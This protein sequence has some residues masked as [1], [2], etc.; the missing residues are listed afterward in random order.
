MALY[1][2]DGI[3]IYNS[4]NLKD[5][6]YES[7]V[8]GFYECP[9]LFELPVDGDSQQKKW[10]MLGAS[11]TYMIGSF[12]GKTFTPENG[13]YAYTYWEMYAAQTFG[14]MNG[15][16][17]QIGWGRPA[18]PGMPFKSM[19][20]IPTELSLVTTKDGV[21]LKSYPIKE[22]DQLKTSVGHWKNLEVA[23]A[24]EKI[25]TF[26]GEEA[27]CIKATIT[28]AV[29]GRRFTL[30]RCGQS[31]VEYDF[32]FSRLNGMHYFL[33]KPDALEMDIEVYM[34]RTSYEVFL[35]G[36]LLSYTLE[37]NKNEKDAEGF[38]V[39]EQ[40][41]KVVDLEVFRMK[42]IWNE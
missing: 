15:R 3:S 32:N 13:K 16:T 10:V 31:I 8:R 28:T 17:V 12:D 19:M 30:K 24:T 9:D 18:H 25:N 42:S 29:T 35:D 7:H 34:D 1:E 38:S 40:D 39:E 36:G 6:T 2:V 20:T 22:M 4:K 33:K 5:W 37:R 26:K 11:Q 21:R 14:N 23:E 41:V 27:L